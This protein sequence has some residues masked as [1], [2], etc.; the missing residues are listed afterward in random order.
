ML[1]RAHETL[2]QQLLAI[3]NEL[4]MARQIQ[5]SILPRQTPRLEGLEIAARYIPMSSVAGDFYDFLVVDEKH[6]G[7]LIA[8]VSG[9]GL[10]SALIA[11]TLQNAIAAQAPHASDAARVLSGLNQALCGKF[12][13]NYY[14]TAAYLFIDMEKGTANYS[15]A[16]HPPLLQWRS[17]TGIA[18]ECLENGLMLGPFSDAT[19][20]AIT[21]PLEEGD[22]IV[23]VTDGIVEAKD[24]CDKEFGMD[25]L[26]EVMQSKHGLAT[27][28]FADA[29]VDEL[30]QW[31]RHALGPSQS[32]DITLLAIDFKCS[33]AKT[34][35]AAWKMHGME[36]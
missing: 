11:S 10:P 30:A 14:V 23:L 28:R 13:S 8:D 18:T 7:V 1:R 20:S 17:K 31:S 22:R 4:E 24:S 2:A 32:D 9:H 33:P 26:R 16:A 29:M 3:N 5:L 34:C 27:N 25:R 6:V 15:G 21:L 35:E 19:Y 36:S 12:M